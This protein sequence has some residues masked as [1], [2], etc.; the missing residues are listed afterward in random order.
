MSSSIKLYTTGNMEK[1]IVDSVT[2]NSA[3]KDLIIDNNLDTFWKPTTGAGDA[4]DI[5]AQE[6]IAVDYIVLFIKNYTELTHDIEIHCEY[7][8]DD[9]SYTDIDSS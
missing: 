3:D 5:D 2:T 6:G 7:S 9:I 4:I 1:A 8:D